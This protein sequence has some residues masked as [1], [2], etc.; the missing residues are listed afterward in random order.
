MGRAALILGLMIVAAAAIPAY[1]AY[2]RHR[3]LVETIAWMEQTYNPQEGGSNYGRGH[4][5]EIH[6]LVHTDTHVE[7]VTESFRDTFSYKGKCNLVIHY[8]T[9]PVGVFKTVYSNGDYTLSLCDID[10]GTI[11]VDKFDWH[12]DAFSC[13]D[14]EQVELF[15]LNCENSEVEFHTW[16]E[17]PKIKDD[18]KT[19]YAD[20]KGKDHESKRDSVSSKGWFIVDDVHYAERFA[21]ALKHAVELCGGKQSKF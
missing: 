2:S 5:E 6:Y 15:T 8:E 4:G 19:T 7:E 10:P 21:K 12:K 20:L 1:R 18:G 11:K 17:I 16:N 13:S 9:I 14:A 3:D